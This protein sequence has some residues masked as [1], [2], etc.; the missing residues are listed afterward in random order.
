MAKG[1]GKGGTEKVFTVIAS[2][3]KARTIIARSEKATRQ[4]AKSHGLTIMSGRAVLQT[5]LSPKGATNA[6]NYR[7]K[8]LVGGN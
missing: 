4:I 1:K 2:D 6:L 3:G 8:D 5:Q 7:A